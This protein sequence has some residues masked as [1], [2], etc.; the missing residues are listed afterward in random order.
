MKKY[1]KPELDIFEFL[2]EAIL[3]SN[4]TF[5]KDVWDANSELL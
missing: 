1:S 3:N 2:G 5:V 4:E